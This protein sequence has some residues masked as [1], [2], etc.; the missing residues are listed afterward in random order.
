M[1]LRR[2]HLADL[3]AEASAAKAAQLSRLAVVF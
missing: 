2:L 1:K 3:I